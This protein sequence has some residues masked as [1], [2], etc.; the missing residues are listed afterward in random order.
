[1][2]LTRERLRALLVIPSVLGQDVQKIVDVDGHEPRI[3]AV[4]G[5]HGRLPR[6]DVFLRRKASLLDGLQE[7][8]LEG[9]HALPHLAIV[10]SLDRRV[11]RRR[12]RVGP[13]GLARDRSRSA[14]TDLR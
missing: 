12:H 7:L 1:M 6:L 3:V 8:G 5:V 11:D 14:A 10:V 9:R 4:V 2:N 13:F